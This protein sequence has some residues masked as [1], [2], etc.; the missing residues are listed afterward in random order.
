MSKNIVLALAVALMMFAAPAFAQTA[1]D[2][3][4]GLKPDK[5]TDVNLLERYEEC[6]AEYS[7]AQKLT[8]EEREKAMLKAKAA[9]EARENQDR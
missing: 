9:L 8:G 6:M 2:N 4:C 3:P 5:S 7:K 1:T